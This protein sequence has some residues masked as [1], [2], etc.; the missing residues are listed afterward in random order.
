M[1]DT[2]M[3]SLKGKSPFKSSSQYSH[4]LVIPV[5]KMAKIFSTQ[6]LLSTYQWKAQ[7]GFGFISSNSIITFKFIFAHHM[8]MMMMMMMM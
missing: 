3:G 2:R 1:S 6:K 4:L 7:T 5:V 8:M